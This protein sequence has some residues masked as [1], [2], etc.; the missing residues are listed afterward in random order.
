MNKA[1]LLARV[2]RGPLT[3]SVH[4]GHIA[5]VDGSGTLLAGVGDPEAL[6]FARSAAKPLQAVP[7]VASGAADKFG[8]SGEQIALMCASH[9]GEPEHVEA[10]ADMLRKLGLSGEALLCGPHYPY[11]E[12]TADRMKRQGI[13]PSRLHNNCSGK[14]A[15]MLA[16]AR[17]TG[18][19]AEDYD[20][21]D[22]PVQQTMLR[23]VAGLAGMPHDRIALGIDGCG[24][25]VFGLPLGQLAR[26]FAA[27]G[28]PDRLDERQANACRSIVKAIRSYPKYIAGDDRFDTH[29]IRATGGRIVGKMGAEGVFAATVP[30]Q[31]A[32]LAVKIADGSARALYAVVVEA[33][34]QLQ[35]LEPD[36]LAVLEPFHQPPIRNWSGRQVGSIAT[37]FRLV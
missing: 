32:A 28:T 26:A 9:N 23:A 31:N 13:E 3:E 30:G 24:V 25:P 34:F 7:V 17:M 15:G 35:W 22:H 33:L 8:F 4:T 1:E 18:A 29:L 6:I 36:E 21:P 11:H 12:P 27:L 20:S 5:V 14:H 10:A 16:L 2:N 37:D 19:T